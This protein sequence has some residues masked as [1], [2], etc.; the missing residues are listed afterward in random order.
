MPRTA[1]SAIPLLALALALSA[2][3]CGSPAAGGGSP[4]DDSR[5]SW[6]AANGGTY[7]YVPA[8]NLL[9][10]QWN[11]ATPQEQ[12]ALDDQTVWHIERYDN[13]YFFGPVAA[14][15]SGFPLATCQYAAGSVTPDGRV[16]I[17]FTGTSTLPAGQPSITTG[18]GRM[19]KVG[20][21]V[22]EM[23]MASGSSSSQVTHWAFMRQCSSG[24]SCWT[25]LPGI[26]ESIPDLLASCGAS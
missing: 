26:G 5:W 14:K 7:W 15:F 18:I 24:Q 17:S 21:W 16:Y 13:G 8:D 10:Y 3:G 25:S 23:Q 22:F 20:G 2:G 1:T 9:A 4:A 6:L 19:T 11:T 12:T